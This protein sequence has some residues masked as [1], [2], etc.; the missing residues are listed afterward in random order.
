MEYLKK[1]NLSDE[2]INEIVEFIDDMDNK[3]LNFNRKNVESI[4]DYFVSIGITCIKDLLMYKTYIFYDSV[5]RI[6]SAF[7]NCDENTIT[8]INNDVMNIDLLIS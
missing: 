1:Y 7:N 6:K 2:D 5:N 8:S 3:E 4:L